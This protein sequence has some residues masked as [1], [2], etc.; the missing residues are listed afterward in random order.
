MLKAKALSKMREI[1]KLIK[2]VRN[3]LVELPNARTQNSLY[4]TYGRYMG[5]VDRI[6]KRTSARRKAA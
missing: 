5:I 1:E 4:N 6:E 3:D 2:D